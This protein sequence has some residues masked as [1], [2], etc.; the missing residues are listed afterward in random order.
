MASSKGN[1]KTIILLEKMLAIQLFSLKMTQDQIARIVGKNKTWVNDL[2]KGL[3]TGGEKNGH[4]K[5]S[6]RH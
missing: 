4:P 2:L 1:D 6:K 5:K 3:T